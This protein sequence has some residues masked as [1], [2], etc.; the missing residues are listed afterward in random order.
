V[1]AKSEEDV[2]KVEDVTE[3]PL[4]TV[5]L[6]VLT[7]DAIVE[8]EILT[9][10]DTLGCMAEEVVDTV[11]TVGPAGAEVVALDI[12]PVVEVP[13]GPTDLRLKSYAVL[14]KRPITVAE[15]A[16]LLPTDC[17]TQAPGPAVVRYSIM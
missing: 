10:V 3:T 8:T 11:V 13:Y 1:T 2:S 5:G 4:T 16:V 17:C 12:A 6:V 14:A 9:E 7:V 15:S